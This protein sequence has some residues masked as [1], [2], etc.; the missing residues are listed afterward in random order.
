VFIGA[1]H[2]GMVFVFYENIAIRLDASGVATAM[3]AGSGDPIFL[4]RVLINLFLLE[5]L[6]RI[7]FIGRDEVKTSG[8]YA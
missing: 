2:F 4:A 1:L 8:I 7:E 6:P 3:M 5:P